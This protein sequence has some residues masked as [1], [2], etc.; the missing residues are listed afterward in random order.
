MTKEQEFRDAIDRIGDHA[1]YHELA[2]NRPPVRELAAWQ[3]NIMKW[4][5]S[6]ITMRKF[7]VDASC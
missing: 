7:D 2:I 5:S 6:G 1:H 4:G 3:A